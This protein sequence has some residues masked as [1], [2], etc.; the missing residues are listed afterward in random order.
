[1][2]NNLYPDKLDTGEITKEELETATETAQ[3]DA[4]KPSTA[5]KKKKLYIP[6]LSTGMPE[7]IG[8][9]LDPRVRDDGQGTLYIKSEY[10][11]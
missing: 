6:Y 10:N 3:I 5:I 9:G 2:E 11:D 8:S 4:Q 1:M 7:A